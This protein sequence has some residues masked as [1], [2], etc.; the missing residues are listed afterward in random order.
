M[1]QY[2]L[3]CVGISLA[4][5]EM[6]LKNNGKTR[7]IREFPQFVQ[8]RNAKSFRKHGTGDGTDP[9]TTKMLNYDSMMLLWLFIK[10]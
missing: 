3:V 1:V 6:F 10:K 8:M 7:K 4:L 9:G 5:Y 2:L